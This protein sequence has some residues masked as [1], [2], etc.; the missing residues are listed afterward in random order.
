MINRRD[1]GKVSVTALAA[2]AA[3]AASPVAAQGPVHVPDSFGPQSE[4]FVPTRAIA[5]VG[6]T[7]IDATGSAPK[8]G[9][10]VVIEG[11]RI[12]RIGRIADVAIPSGAERIDCT[13]LTIM[14]GVIAS[15]QSL[16]LN[17]LYPAPAAD[18]PFA[19]IKGRWEDNYKQIPTHAFVYL[20]QGTTSIRQ[21]NGPWKQLLPIKK[22][23]DAGELPGPRVMLG[24]ALFMSDRYFDFYV[25]S[26]QSPPESIDWLRNEFAYNVISDVERDTEAFESKDF[27]FWKL[28]MNDEVYDGKNDF[29][30]A[31]IRRLIERGHTLGKRIDCH[32]GP[33]NA[34]MRRMTQF[35]IDTL[36]HPFMNTVLTD[37]DI[38]QAYARKHVI[39]ASLL[40]IMVN[41]AA[42]I[43]DPHQL[44]EAVYFMS[45]RP[46]EYRL[47]MQYRDKMRFLHA[48]PAQG[49]VPLYQG[50]VKPGAT[51][52]DT[53]GLKGPSLNELQRRAE[54]AR[55]NM[56]HYIEAGVKLSLGMDTPTFLNFPQSDP[57]VG[58]FQ[59]MID[60]GLTPMEAV[61]AA[62][63]NG[64]EALGMLDT[65][66]T[67]E[68]G[69]FADVIAL[70]GDPL[71]DSAAFKR[72]AI[73]IKD[74]VRYK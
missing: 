8:Q 1:F 43:E 37:P 68:T 61:Q 28:Y 65:L 29:S 30:D 7:L 38:I 17:P 50:R 67:I 55:T 15:N 34:G 20:M 13:G 74:G 51:A 57:T 24:G 31:E 69:K 72:V 33:H 22:R 64:A 4:P 73:V 16:Q 5:L 54:I 9:H 71:T 40:T 53:F 56:R 70:A 21:T 59:A 66:G 19:Q 35:D 36:E 62:T 49:G 46:D 26:N 60:L 41:Q 47:L 42:L 52:R 23:I 14:P 48:N 32:A 12:T 45:M 39:A 58:E 2:G 10:V 44:D 25:R 63:R 18:L 6:G 3:V 11:S 27:A